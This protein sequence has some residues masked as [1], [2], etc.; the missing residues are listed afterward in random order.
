MIL[1]V[2]CGIFPRVS[3]AFERLDERC[4][5]IGLDPLPRNVERA[6][7]F[8][9]GRLEDLAALSGFEPRFD[10]FVFGTSLDHLEDLPAAAAAIRHLAS[11]GAVLVCWNGLQEP[12]RTV[13]N[14]AVAVFQRLL[15][16][17]S[18]V[19][20]IVAYFGYGVLRLPRLLM[21]MR[22]RRDTLARGEVMDHHS[23]WFTESNSARYLGEF[24]E[25]IDM[26][27]LPNTQH[28]FAT[29]RVGEAG[30]TTRTS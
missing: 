27:S 30:V 23:R 19:A 12:E 4:Q 9:C 1:D 25:V 16:Y 3:P 8:V 29:V 18:T 11:P 7:P 13:T 10:L 15:R 22:T 20:A 24:G 17:R 2:G 5:Y 6:Y 14:H 21:R 26:T 28:G